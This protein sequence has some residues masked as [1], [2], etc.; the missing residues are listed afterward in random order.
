MLTVASAPI[1]ELCMRPVRWAVPSPSLLSAGAGTPQCP[2]LAAA[3][4]FTG[5]VKG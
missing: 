4:G 2:G 5:L 1:Y 3:V